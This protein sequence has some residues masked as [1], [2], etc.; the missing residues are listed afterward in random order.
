MKTKAQKSRNGNSVGGV[1]LNEETVKPYAKQ[2]ADL[3][4]KM[5]KD[6]EQMSTKE[7]VDNAA[8]DVKADAE[9]NTAKILASLDANFKIAYPKKFMLINKWAYIDAIGSGDYY[10]TRDVPTNRRHP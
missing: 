2:L 3:E 1:V 7:R 8:E 9:Q 4:A 10:K 5:A 6:K